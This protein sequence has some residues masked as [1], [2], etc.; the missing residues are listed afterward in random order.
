MKILFRGRTLRLLGAAQ[1]GSHSGCFATTAFP[2]RNTHPTGFAHKN[3][4]SENNLT[5]K[6]I[7]L[8]KKKATLLVCVE[9]AAWAQGCPQ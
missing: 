4:A 6:K 2:P 5:C 7:S 1:R 9:F 3:F 8:R